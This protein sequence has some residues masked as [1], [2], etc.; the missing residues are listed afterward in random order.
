MQ[1][2]GAYEWWYFD[3]EDK[4]SGFSFVLIWFSGFPF[5]PYYTS[6]Y[7]KWK[8]RIT[9]DAPFPSNYSG[10]S[11]Q[12]YENGREIVNFIREGRMGFL[13]A[14]VPISVSGLKRTGLSYDA[15]RDEYALDIDFSFPARHKEVKATFLFKSCRRI[16]LRK[17]RYEQ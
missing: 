2:P 10:F 6:H 12:L 1:E 13:K 8:N 17:K 14:A 3:A 16:R 11:F 5:S 15:L 7:E 4:E 9:S